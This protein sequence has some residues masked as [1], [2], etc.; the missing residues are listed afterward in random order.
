MSMH[1]DHGRAN[2][3]NSLVIERLDLT[4]G[5]VALIYVVIGLL[6]L[7]G[8]DVLLIQYFDDPMLSKLQ[9]VK[10]VVEV[11]LTG[12]LIYGLTRGSRAPLEVHNTRLARQ[13]EELDVLHRVLRHNLRNDLN[14]IHGYTQLLHT[15][16]D[17]DTDTAS[18]QLEWCETVLRN[19]EGLLEYTERAEEIRR[20]TDQDEAPTEFDLVEVIPSLLDDNPHVTDRVSID[21]DLPDK[22]VVAGNHML[23]AAIDE[24]VSN[25]IEHNPSESPWV[26]VTIAES[27]GLNGRMVLEI[28]DNGPGISEHAV[29]VLEQGG[30]DRLLHLESLGLWFVHWT[31]EE[32]GGNLEI[33]KIRDGALVRVI[34][35]AATSVN[36]LSLA[37]SV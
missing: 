35:P 5:R 29:D 31:V 23:P 27:S 24:L 19:V 13:R 9:A 22:A 28:R 34:L 25:A 33:S 26:G 6:A 1:T 7:Y 8:S 15:N 4:P 20:I 12:V 32:S 14:I 16:H 18:A 37:S 2:L 30:E 21:L 36:P 3:A 17:P 10:G 11:G